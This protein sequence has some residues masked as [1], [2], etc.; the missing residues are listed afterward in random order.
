MNPA[1]TNL[2]LRDIHL[3]E[4]ISW[5][6]P[7]PGWWLVLGMVISICVIAYLAYRYHQHRRLHRAA[8]LELQ[9]I[10]Q[11][12]IETSDSQ[13]LVRSLSIWLR[14]VCLS[15]Y[16]RADV[17]G[18]TGTA[19]L[20]FLDQ[21]LIQKQRPERFSDETGRLLNHAPYRPAG[22]IETD[23]LLALCQTWLQCLPRRRGRQP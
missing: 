5:W 19:W 11:A 7:A 14:R 23:A 20:E 18:L 12:F 22:H 16:P 2:Q 17:A 10:Q 4:S 9:K 8:R 13:L 1:P 21:A 6:P 15:F 3:P